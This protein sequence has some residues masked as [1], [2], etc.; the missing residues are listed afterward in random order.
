MNAL[1]Y[2]GEEYAVTASRRPA[3][4]FGSIALRIVTRSQASGRQTAF[5]FDAVAVGER[6]HSDSKL[7]RGRASPMVQ[8]RGCIKNSVVIEGLRR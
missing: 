8:T 7:L 5:P 4:F 2:C 1:K 3:A 6:L